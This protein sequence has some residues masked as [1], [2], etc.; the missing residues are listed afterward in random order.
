M[1]MKKRAALVQAERANRILFTIVSIYGDLRSI[2]SPFRDQQSTAKSCSRGSLS[3]RCPDGTTKN[4]TR[5]AH[6]GVW[7]SHF[8]HGAAVRLVIAFLLPC[9]ITII[10]R[11]QSNPPP[12]LKISWLS[13]QL[14]IS[15]LNSVAGR[16][17]Q[18][19]TRSSLD[20]STNWT[21]T[22]LGTLGQTN[23]T[24]ASPSN[25]YRLFRACLLTDLPPQI[26]SFTASPATLATN[27]TSTLHWSVLGATSL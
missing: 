8:I 15:I 14:Q 12:F 21:P 27:G 6:N 24:I 2:A 18:I 5:A 7:S 1:R 10:G 4:L 16:I 22:F 20:K 25:S 9:F 11:A 17:Y 19:E 3:V 26:L 23:F 13:N